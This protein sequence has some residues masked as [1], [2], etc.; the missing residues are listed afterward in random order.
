MSSAREYVI[1][2][3]VA[4]RKTRSETPDPAFWPAELY[5]FSNTRGTAR[6]KVGRKAARSGSRLRVSGV[7]PST[8][9]DGTLSTWMKRANTCASG[10]NSS[11]RE[12]GLAQTS[13]SPSTPLSV[14]ATKLPC[15]SSTPLGLP[16][17]PEV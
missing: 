17:V 7:C 4:H 13:R 10:M 12:Y 9:P 1:A 3:L 6:M 11:V 5:T 15:V 8:A 14:S 16:V 2:T